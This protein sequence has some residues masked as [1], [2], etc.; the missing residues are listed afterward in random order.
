MIAAPRRRRLRFLPR[1]SVRNAALAVLVLVVLG[2]GWLWFRSSSLVAIKQVRVTGLSGPDVSQ[3]RHDLTSQAKLMTTLDVDVSRLQG[4]VS[5]YPD[6]RSLQVAT[7]FPHSVVIHVSEQVPVATIE[8]GGGLVVVDTDGQLLAHASGAPSPLPL[9]PLRTAPSGSR[10][11]AAGARAAIA[12]LAAAPYALITHIENATSTA[13]HGVIVQLRI[14]PQLYFGSVAQL[15]AKWSAA[16]AVLSESSSA[17]ADYID[18]TD[19]RRA[20]A[21]AG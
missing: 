14:G 10:V 9:V 1:L 16:L 20:A 4:A 5:Q 8:V 19:P 6:V 15:A 11:S 18:V 2:C 17:G 7:G 3:I 13:S 21:G 12:T